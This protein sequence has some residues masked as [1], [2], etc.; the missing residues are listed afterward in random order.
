MFT[1]QNMCMTDDKGIIFNSPKLETTQKSINNTMNKTACIA[2][3]AGLIP[4][5]GRSPGGRNGHPFQY[6]CLENPT[7]RRAWQAAVHG[8]T[9]SVSQF[10]RSVLSDS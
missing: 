6:S 2:G 4:G 7:D 8:V 5:L 10:S 1:P 3:V 9:K